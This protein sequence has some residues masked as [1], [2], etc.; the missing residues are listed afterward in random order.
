MHKVYEFDTLQC[1][2]L[3]L[4]TLQVYVLIDKKNTRCIFLVQNIIHML[5][6]L[7]MPSHD[8]ILY[9]LKWPY[10][11]HFF[12]KKMVATKRA[13]IVYSGV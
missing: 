7:K 10:H 12:M 6:F 13:K 3:R 1:H 8:S 5:C 11:S 2:L 4:C 9:L